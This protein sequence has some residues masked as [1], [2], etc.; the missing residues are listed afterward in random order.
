MCIRPELGGA[1]NFD[2]FLQARELAEL[3]RSH[4]ESTIAAGEAHLRSRAPL[5]WRELH[6]AVRKTAEFK[7]YKGE[8]FVWRAA[9]GYPPA[10]VL[11]NISASFID[12][13]WDS[14]TFAVM[15][16]GIPGV[17]SVW[18][19]DSPDPEF[20]DVQFRGL[21][22]WLIG[23]NTVEMRT[24]GEDSAAEAICK[25]LVTYFDDYQVSRGRLVS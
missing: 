10:L 14:R 24:S 4:R 8:R 11:K 16:S 25:A 21:D 6:D 13:E 2:E 15:L 12:R 18:A 9:S 1:M 19:L 20:I 5:A 7:H 17:Q 23:A 22:R 3:K